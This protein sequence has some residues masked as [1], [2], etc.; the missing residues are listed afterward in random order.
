[1]GKLFFTV[2]IVLLIGGFMIKT[3]YDL[4]LSN[5]SDQKI[6]VVEMVKWVWKIG[7]NLVKLT[8]YAVHLNWSP[9]GDNKTFNKTNNISLSGLNRFIDKRPQGFN[10]SILG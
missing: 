2:L 9:V 10:S 4:S 3:T 8:G 1:M 5:K 6:L 7:R